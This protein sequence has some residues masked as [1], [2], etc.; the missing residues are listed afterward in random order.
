M[1]TSVTLFMVMIVNFSFHLDTLFMSNKMNCLELII[2]IIDLTVPYTLLHVIQLLNVI[3]LYV[4]C[5]H[6]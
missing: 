6:F 3:T 2:L 4:I 1:L 5:K